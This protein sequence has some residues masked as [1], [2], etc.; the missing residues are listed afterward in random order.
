M[1]PLGCIS[2]PPVIGSCATRGLRMTSST[3]R[4]EK[5]I[6][7]RA[8]QAPDCGAIS[9]PADVGSCFGI[10]LDGAVAPGAEL[11]GRIVPTTADPEIAKMQQPHVGK[12]VVLF[13]DR[14]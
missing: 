13:I 7:L 10:G 6:E 1:Q 4:I 12:P 8:P 5:R 2:P 9:D 3:D 11:P 14:V